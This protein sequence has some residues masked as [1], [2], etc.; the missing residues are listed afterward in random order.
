[1]NISSLSD[2]CFVIR[3]FVKK[4]RMFGLCYVEGAKGA[5]NLR[6]YRRASRFAV[7]C[8]L[9]TVYSLVGWLGRAPHQVNGVK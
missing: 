7:C 8:V 1:M 4:T 9:F 6:H 5:W 3:N 2:W